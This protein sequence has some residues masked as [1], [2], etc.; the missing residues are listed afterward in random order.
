MLSCQLE[1]NKAIEQNISDGV[2]LFI[3]ITLKPLN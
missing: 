2:E 3:E 1:L